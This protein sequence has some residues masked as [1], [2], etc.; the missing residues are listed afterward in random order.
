MGKEIDRMITAGLSCRNAT[1]IYEYYSGIN[2]WTG[3]ENYIRSC[4]SCKD[5]GGKK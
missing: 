4:E 5:E 3:L 1:A 2:D